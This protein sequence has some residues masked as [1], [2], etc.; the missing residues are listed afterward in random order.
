MLEILADNA[1]FYLEKYRYNNKIKDLIQKYNLQLKLLLSDG[2]IMLYENKYQKIL[3]YLHY[4][5]NTKDLTLLVTIN[6]FTSKKIINWLSKI[7]L[8]RYITFLKEEKTK[9]VFIRSILPS[10]FYFWEN[11]SNFYLKHWLIKSFEKIQT[12]DSWYKH[13][14]WNL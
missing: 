6:W 1:Y 14:I 9:K 12:L 11:I 2:E 5:P 10:A 4:L 3:W 13:F 7:L 8:N